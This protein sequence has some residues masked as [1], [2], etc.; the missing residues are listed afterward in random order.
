MIN[1]NFKNFTEF[2]Q[3]EEISETLLLI[4]EESVKI[5]CEHKIEG[6]IWHT[7]AEPIVN[8]VFHILAVLCSR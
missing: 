8:P 4:V 6:S 3:R 2:I 5:Y 7:M 1:I